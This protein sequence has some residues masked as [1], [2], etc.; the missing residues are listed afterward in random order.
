MVLLWSLAM[1][2]YLQ[3][4]Q[5]YSHFRFEMNGVSDRG[6][7]LNPTRGHCWDRLL[8]IEDVHAGFVVSSEFESLTIANASFSSCEYFFSIAVTAKETRRSS[9]LGMRCESVAPIL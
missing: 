3:H 5:Y 1:V 2:A 7:S 8:F 6:P 4:G 9:P